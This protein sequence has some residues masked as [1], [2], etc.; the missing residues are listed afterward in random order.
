MTEAEI[1]KLWDP[2]PDSIPV[3]GHRGIC[4]KYPE[5][6]LVSF[7]A[8]IDL[9]VDLIEFDV[10]VTKDGELV[11][12]HDNE[13]DRTSNHT[14]LTRDYTLAELKTFDFGGWFGEEFKG[15][16]IPTL[17]EV[18]ELVNSRSKTLIL[19]VEIKDMTEEAVD[20]TT[21]MLTQYGLTDRCVIACFDAAVIR[22]TKAAHPEF[23]TQGFPGRYM[24]NFTPETYDCMF[25][26]GIPI[27]WG[28]CTEEQIMADVAFAN[29]RGILPWLFAADTEE[30]VRLCVKC[31]TANITGNNPEVALTTLRKM[32]LHQ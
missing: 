10:N 8:A 25:G 26:M 12:I 31:G 5:N 20:K 11:V 28:G 19:N 4:A 17:R 32:G 9:G 23:R 27:S 6:T 24:Q 30:G 16:Q 21:A 2:R 18:L 1:K 29:A 13:I 22:Y 3:L 15:A 14:G 7:A